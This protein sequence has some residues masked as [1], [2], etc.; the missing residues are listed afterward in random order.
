MPVGTF[1]GM[2]LCFSI[3]GR[4]QVPAP[5]PSGFTPSPTGPP[6][7]QAGQR[8]RMFTCRGH[9]AVLQDSRCWPHS[10]S[11]QWEASGRQQKRGVSPP[12]LPLED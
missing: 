8:K 6:S 12:P 9:L 1:S 11:W 2:S 7:G 5:G 4:D 10:A 3:S